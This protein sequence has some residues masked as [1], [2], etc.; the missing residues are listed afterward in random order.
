LQVRPNRRRVR[1]KYAMTERREKWERERRKTNPDPLI[2]P[3][4]DG[5][6]QLRILLRD[7]AK[8]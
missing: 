4:R 2:R 7:M 1:A 6:L 8:V 5:S 3:D